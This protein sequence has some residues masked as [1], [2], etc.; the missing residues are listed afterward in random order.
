MQWQTVFQNVQAVA[1]DVGSISGGF[2]SLNLLISLS[3][4]AVLTIVS[5]V[6]RILDGP[7]TLTAIVLGVMVGTLGHWTWLLILLCFLVGGHWATRWS[8][9]E[10]SARGL[11]ESKDGMRHWQ[12]VVANGGVP[13]LVAVGAFITRIG[14][15]CS[16]CSL[17]V[18]RLRQQTP[19]PASSAASMIESG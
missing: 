7:G 18:W 16:R 12:N 15:D 3:L 10:K 9:D 4:V 8:W 11:A 19:S 5:G 14:T 17:A 2:D 1:L 13:G 6:K